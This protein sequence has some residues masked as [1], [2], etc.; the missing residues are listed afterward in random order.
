VEVSASLSG[1]APGS[2]IRIGPSGRGVATNR[3][4][5]RPDRT[6]TRLHGAVVAAPG[7]DGR[8]EFWRASAPIRQVH[9]R[10]EC[11][12]GHA[13]TEDKCHSSAHYYTTGAALAHRQN[14]PFGFVG[15]QLRRNRAVKQAVPRHE[16]NQGA[17]PPSS[18]LPV[19][20]NYGSGQVT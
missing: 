7:G 11:V 8:P 3:S 2:D 10:I 5:R 13:R 4:I 1:G 14:L 18:H 9:G 17:S 19:L 15:G 6:S 20:S 16:T 12:P